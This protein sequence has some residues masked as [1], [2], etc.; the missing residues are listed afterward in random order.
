MLTSSVA[1]DAFPE[2]HPYAIWPLILL[3]PWE[4]T[5]IKLTYIREK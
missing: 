3:K 4:L 5:A 2:N 1:L